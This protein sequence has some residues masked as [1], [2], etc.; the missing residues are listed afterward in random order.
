[1]GGSLILYRNG[2][3]CPRASVAKKFF[4]HSALGFDVTSSVW[5]ANENKKGESIFPFIHAGR[6]RPP[7]NQDQTNGCCDRVSVN[8]RIAPQ[9]ERQ[10]VPLLTQA[11]PSIETELCS[12]QPEDIALMRRRVA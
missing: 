4:P 11:V 9:A 7:P 12:R 6:T 1:M 8:G 2:L 3:G 5:L 10:S